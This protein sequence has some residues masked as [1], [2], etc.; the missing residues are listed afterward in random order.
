M[1]IAHLLAFV[2]CAAAASAQPLTTIAL[3]G[4]QAPDLEAGVSYARLSPPALGA[5]GRVVF[6]ATLAGDNLSEDLDEAL[7][8]H[9]NGG[10]SL[11]VRE[12]DPAPWYAPETRFVGL[13]DF[14]IDTAGSV[15]LAASVDDP[16]V[17]DNA[18]KARA[19]GIFTQV[20]PGTFAALARIDDQAAG[21]PEG[22]LYET[23]N[24][25]AVAPDGQSF[26]TGGR[27]DDGFDSYAKGLW[28]DR[29]GDVTLLVMPGDPAPDTQ[30]G[31][32]ANVETPT[33]GADGGFIFRGSFR[34]EGSAD[35]AAQGLWHEIQGT[36]EALALAGNPAPGTTGTF[37]AFAAQPTRNSASAAAF[38]ATLD[39][40]NTEADEGVWSDRTGSLGLLVREGDAA[41]GIADATIGTISPHIRMN[42]AGDIA[43]RCTLL[44]TGTD[45]NGAI[46]LAHADGSFTLIAQEGDI[47]ADEVESVVIA[48]L[49]D[50]LLDAQGQLLFRAHL[51]G[52]SVLPTTNDALLAFDAQG[53]VYSIVR[54]GEQFDPDGSGMRTIK[55]I[56]VDTSAVDRGRTPLDDAGRVG[57]ALSFTDNTFGAFVTTIGYTSPADF[58]G[59][60]IVDTRD[61]VAFLDAWATLDPAADLDL[62]GEINT[63]DFVAFLNFWSR[64]RE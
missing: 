44:G 23:L 19:L 56:A 4:Q 28:T 52:E 61:F 24:S 58:N 31:L 6:F 1:N 18:T 34:P 36:L 5:D 63:S 41:P 16:A 32:F 11:L 9:L 22:D 20:G 60:G 50:P 64:D 55:S 2:G 53:A 12:S 35:P 37:K 40:N 62:N 42:E 26:F 10:G 33:P 54:E 21:L 29:T 48:S 13:S 51:A 27:P 57:F 30:D 7:F 8:F 39:T 43:F 46:Y 15:V 49:G 59:D 45:A 17:V 3:T 38:R 47:I 25:P 14:A